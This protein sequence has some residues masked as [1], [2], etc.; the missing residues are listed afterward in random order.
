MYRQSADA[1]AGAGAVVVGEPR[2]H[3]NGRIRSRHSNLSRDEAV[4]T[5][6]VAFDHNFEV[7]AHSLGIHH[8]RKQAVVGHVADGKKVDADGAAEVLGVAVGKRAH[9]TAAHAHTVGN[10][11][12]GMPEVGCGILVEVFG[13]MVDSD[14]QGES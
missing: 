14:T 4:C 10:V 1:D 9:H 5:V 13:D 7:G 6:S 8:S 12:A 2:N 11:L 3:R